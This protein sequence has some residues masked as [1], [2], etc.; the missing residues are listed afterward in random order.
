VIRLFDPAKENAVVLADLHRLCFA[1][2]WD[3]P[4]IERLA[5]GPGFALI[6]GS[7]ADG[8]VL[9]RVAAGEAEILTLAVHPH[10]RRR[11]AAHALV[12]EAC[13]QAEARGA[14]SMFLE[15]D[16]E[17]AAA[18]ALYEQLG[19]TKAGERKGYYRSQNGQ[20]RDA[21]VMRRDL[22][23]SPPAV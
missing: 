13:R 9:A 21:F 23:L 17:N 8:F 10:R 5:T 6:H 18:R 14:E 11:G 7:P 3:G 22:P 4:A 19:F 20:V 12:V 2:P 1:D 15:V 16:S